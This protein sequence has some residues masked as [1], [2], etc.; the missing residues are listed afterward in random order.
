MASA[1]LV[2]SHARIRNV[3]E[4]P[5]RN[6]GGQAYTREISGAM[7]LCGFRP[8]SRGHEGYPC[9]SQREA[10]PVPLGLFLIIFY[11]LLGSLNLALSQVFP[12]NVFFVFSSSCFQKISP[13]IPTRARG[14]RLELTSL[15]ICNPLR[16]A[17]FLRLYHASFFFPV[18][19]ANIQ[20][21]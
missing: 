9:E 14:Q 2:R 21:I 5:L 6:L 7:A 13:G 16:S 17:A 3:N 12:I 8:H 15:A 20:V 1:P 18:A 10:R 4:S 19:T 11:F